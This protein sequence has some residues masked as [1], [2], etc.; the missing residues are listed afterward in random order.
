M[1]TLLDLIDSSTKAPAGTDG[2]S[3]APTLL[4]K[5]QKARK[6]LYREFGGYGGQ[7]AVWMGRWKGIR[8]NIVRKSNKTPLKIELYDLK[9]DI[10]ESRDVAAENPKVVARIK[11]LKIDE[12]TN[13]DVFK[14][15]PLDT[16]N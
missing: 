9:K 5:K 7:Q 2:V 10:A 6:F 14:M 16:E 8:H 15:A 11:K 4:G 1:P 13:S 12:H 3:I